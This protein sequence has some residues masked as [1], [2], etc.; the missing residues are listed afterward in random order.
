MGY[1]SCRTEVG[2]LSVFIYD[3]VNFV[4]ENGIAVGERIS[5]EYFEILRTIRRSKWYTSNPAVACI[6]I[7]A[8]DLLNQER[9][10]LEAAGTALKSLTW[11]NGGRNHLVWNMLPGGPPNYEP[12]LEVPKGLAM[13]AGAGYSISSFR[14]GF[15]ISIPVFN[16]HM[17]GPPLHLHHEYKWLAAVPQ[18]HLLSEFEER[19]EKQAKN[20]NILQFIPC[21]R[22][23]IPNYRERCFSNGTSVLYPE[24]LTK[25]KFCLIFRDV[26]T[27]LLVLQDALKAGC[28]PVIFAD[29]LVLPFFEVID[30]TKIAIHAW[31][32]E[33]IEVMT[34]LSQ[35]PDWHIEEMKAQGKWVFES[36]FST[37]EK[38]THT[39]LEILESRLFPHLQKS[40]EDWNVRP[41]KNLVKSPLLYPMKLPTRSFGFT[42]VILTY[43][44]LSTLFTVINRIAQ[45]PSLTKVLVVWNNVDTPPPP[46]AAFYHKYWSFAYWTKL[47]KEIK[48]WVDENMNCEDIA[49]NFL[50]SHFTHKG[51]IKVGPRKKFRYPEY[52]NAQLSTDLGHMKRRSE[53]IN[54]F[55][56]A[57][58]YMPLRSVE[59]RADPVLY[60]DDFPDKLKRFPEVGTL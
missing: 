34:L 33:F 52:Q 31:E 47:P 18:E 12:F 23:P 56:G 32:H 57:F 58:G 11:W 15:D 25:S 22:G 41:T 8:L 3:Y 36:Y 20:T 45:T 38:I 44:R 13:V 5:K 37:I 10:R 4:D 7:P 51:P 43:D 28:V 48:E 60:K 21:P 27:T 49:M 19:V 55:A 6:F 1:S 46:G 16:S 53:C 30:W 54:R 59:F 29:Q 2:S 9:I 35:V 50:V 39:T 26:R 17:E 24:I 42:A 14:H 40:Y